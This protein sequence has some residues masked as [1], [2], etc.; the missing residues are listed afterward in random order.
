MNG[1][2][3]LKAKKRKTEGDKDRCT[4]ELETALTSIVWRCLVSAGSHMHTRKHT[5]KHIHTQRV[6]TVSR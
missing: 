2:T 3:D 4:E 6:I 5:H 1:G